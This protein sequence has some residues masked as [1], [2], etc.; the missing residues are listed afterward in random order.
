MT[1][2]TVNAAHGL[3]GTCEEKTVYPNIKWIHCIIQREALA[4]YEMS[5]ELSAVLDDVVN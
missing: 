5:P 1:G 4:R 2:T 3:L